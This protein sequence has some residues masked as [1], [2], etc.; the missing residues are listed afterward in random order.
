VPRLAPA[1][2]WLAGAYAYLWLLTD[3]PPSIE[4]G[5][6]A[7]LEVHPSGAPTATTALTRLFTSLPAVLILWI[8][9]IAAGLLWPIGAIF[10][11]VRKRLPAV[12][13]DFFLLMLRGQFR[14]IGYHLSLVDRYPTFEE[15]LGWRDTSRS[16]ST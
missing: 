4:P 1:L 12:L 14:V 3:S 6:V 11:L 16:T 10:I 8:L 15:R 7:E 13:F 5:R 2:R 9:S